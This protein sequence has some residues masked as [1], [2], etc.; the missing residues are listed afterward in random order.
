VVLI[1]GGG[2]GIGLATAVAFRKL[3]AKV[4]I[5]DID[6]ELAQRCY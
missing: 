5:G 1:T 3:G 2:R 6:L 4:A